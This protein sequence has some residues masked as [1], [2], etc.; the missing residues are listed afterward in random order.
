V[1]WRPGCPI[2]SD[3]SVNTSGPTSARPRTVR[4]C[5][6]FETRVN[7][8]LGVPAD[9]RGAVQCTPPSYTLSGISPQPPA[10]NSLPIC[11]DMC[12]VCRGWRCAGSK[13]PRPGITGDIVMRYLL[14][15][16]MSIFML[17]CASNRVIEKDLN[18]AEILT[19][20]GTCSGDCSVEVSY[21][22]RHELCTA[23]GLGRYQPRWEEPRSRLTNAGE[24][25]A[26]NGSTVA[27]SCGRRVGGRP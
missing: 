22:E 7:G 15:A 10:S 3:H 5:Q 23:S 14:L 8:R 2:E 21:H 24:A 20:Q 12:P 26:R 19:A 13:E 18:D 17:G 16:L 27:P 6:W 11:P 4:Q 1:V 9:A 25:L